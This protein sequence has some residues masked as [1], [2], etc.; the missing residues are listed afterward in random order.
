[1]ANNVNKKLL[2]KKDMN[3]FAE[4]TASAA[5]A[6]RMLSLAVIAGVAV[7]AIIVLF[8][9]IGLVNNA[10]LKG[11]INKIETTL[12]DEKYTQLEGQAADLAQKLEQRTNYFYAL[13]QMRAT[14]DRIPSAPASLPDV[15]GECIPNDSYIQS[16][17]ITGTTLKITGE[18][19]TYYSPVDMVEMLNESDVFTSKTLININRVTADEIGSAEEL[20]GETINCINNYYHFEIEGT[21]VSD[22]YVTI[23]R[24]AMGDTVTSLAGTETLKFAAGESFTLTDADNQL[25]NYTTETG[26]AYTLSKITING[27]EVN[28]DDFAAI[29]ASGSMSEFA[30][31]EKDI[32]LYYTVVEEAPAESEEA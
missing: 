29:L 8:I 21:L 14:V 3:F 5:K 13:T 22:I 27:I 1:M 10:I 2:S 6:A 16:Y 26:T 20:Y 12:A 4:F 9:I 24:L 7:L 32:K 17:E 18:S 15:I 23:S 31:G 25:V 19:F 30:N 28:S 11:Q